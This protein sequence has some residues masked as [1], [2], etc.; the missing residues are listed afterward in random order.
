MYNGKWASRTVYFSSLRYKPNIPRTPATR[1]NWVG[2]SVVMSL[3]VTAWYAA[4]T[5]ITSVKAINTWEIGV[6]FD[7]LR[8]DFLAIIHVCIFLV[9]SQMAG[10]VMPI[11]GII[12]AHLGRR[13]IALRRLKLWREESPDSRKRGTGC[14]PRR[15]SASILSTEREK[16]QNLN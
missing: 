6:L 10:L 7:D 2:A 8:A 4:T 1:N 9:I 13:T 11:F 14:K 16:R 3:C 15:E 5:I 12:G